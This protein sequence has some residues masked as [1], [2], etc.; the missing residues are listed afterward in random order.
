MLE[1]QPLG[2]LGGSVFN[3]RFG[4]DPRETTPEV[5]AALLAQAKD[6]LRAEIKADVLV[7]AEM[8]AVAADKFYDVLVEG[9]FTAFAASEI[10]IAFIQSKGASAC[11]TSR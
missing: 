5:Y 1:L 3:S 11:M 4:Y 6:E 2:L 7:Q 10:T 9:K 8:A